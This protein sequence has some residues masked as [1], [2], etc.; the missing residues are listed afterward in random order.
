MTH[1]WTFDGTWPHPPQWF[2]TPDGRMHFVDVGHRAGRPVVLVHG[3][4]SWGYLFRHFIAPLVSAGHRVIVPDHLGFGRSDKPDRPGVYAIARHAQRLEALLESLALEQVT[5][6]PHD[7]G[8]PIALAWATRHP[9]RIAALALLGTFVHRPRGR[10]PMP[11]PLRLFRVRGIGELLVRGLHAILRGFLF[12]AGTMRQERL[13][14]AERAAYLA[15]HPTWASRGAVLAFARDFPAGPEGDVADLLD[16]IHAQLARLAALPTLLVWAG[17]DAVFGPAGLAAFRADFPEAE[18]L[19]VPDA[20]HFIQEDAHEIV[21]PALLAF[22]RD[23][24]P[25]AGAGAPPP[26]PS[27]PRAAPS[28]HSPASS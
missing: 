7:W 22:L 26:A 11:L 5:L 18:V 3:N 9:A 4:P 1:D 23:R 10:V 16:G 17:R 13:G 20:G 8:G 25:A 15:P 19:E 24:S 28:H 12:G 14:R 21:V 6:V 27:A 2:D